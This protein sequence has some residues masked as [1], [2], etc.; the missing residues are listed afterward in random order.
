MLVPFYLSISSEFPV[1]LP[2]CLVLFFILWQ[3]WAQ[4]LWSGISW[5]TFSW[6][7]VMI[8]FHVLISCFIALGEMSVQIRCSSNA[9]ESGRVVQMFLRHF[10]WTIPSVFVCSFL[11]VFNVNAPLPPR[12]EQEVKE[13]PYSPGYNQN[14]TSAS[15]QTISQCQL[16]AIHIEQTAQPPDTGK[17]SV[18]IL[19]K[20]HV[21]THPFTEVPSVALE[22]S[23]NKKHF[24]W[25]FC[26]CPDT[27]RSQKKDQ[28][29]WNWSCG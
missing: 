10:L 12:E 11:K 8:R 2:P 25:V 24:L 7:L 22:F 29:S 17:T 23:K 21:L 20:Y 9:L 27:F 1:S 16:P 3:W 19:H 26:S 6:W 4:W 18:Y 28:I 14:F 13:C 5:F 15:M